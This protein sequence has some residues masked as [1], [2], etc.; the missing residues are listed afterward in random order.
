[1]PVDRDTLDFL[2][3]MLTTGKIP[4][5]D[6]P[7]P[8]PEWQPPSVEPDLSSYRDPYT[9]SLGAAYDRRYSTAYDEMLREL[10][11]SNGNTQDR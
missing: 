1:M 8:A 2:R 9:H 3:D 6:K 11:A 7:K 4:S 10:E 5:E